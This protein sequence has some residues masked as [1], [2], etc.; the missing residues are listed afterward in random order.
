MACCTGRILALHFSDR[1]L[2][3]FLQLCAKSALIQCWRAAANLLCCD[4]HVLRTDLGAGVQRTYTAFSYLY[5]A[6]SEL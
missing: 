6:Y 5:F 3:A 4:C 1:C 2:L